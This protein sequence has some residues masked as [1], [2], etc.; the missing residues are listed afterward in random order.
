MQNLVSSL[1]AENKM[2]S[3]TP[4]L[5]LLREAVDAQ[6]PKLLKVILDG[7]LRSLIWWAVILLM[8]G[9][10]NWTGIKVP[11]NQSHSVNL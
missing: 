6:T 11:S 4:L 5:I 2:H 8:A 9:A 3:R 10:W 7:A 1:N